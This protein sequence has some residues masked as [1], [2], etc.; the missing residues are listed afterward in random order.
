MKKKYFILFLLP[1]LCFITNHID[2]QFYSGQEDYTTTSAK[3]RK[4]EKEKTDENNSVPPRNAIELNLS[5]AFLYNINLTYERKIGRK[6]GVLLG[7]RYGP[8]L[9]LPF[10]S[11]WGG[12]IKSN[13]ITNFNAISLSNIAITP[14]IRY[15]FGKGFQRGFYIAGYARYV[16]YN[17]S[18]PLN[19][20]YNYQG[21]NISQNVN[22]NTN[23]SGIS[24]GLM[25]GLQ[26]PIGKHFQID[27][28]LIGVNYGKILT[29]QA[30]ASTPLLNTDAYN[31]LDDQIKSLQNGSASLPI[32]FNYSLSQTPS[33]TNLK[34]TVNGPI[35]GIRGLGINFGFRF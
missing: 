16:S 11:Q 25:F 2:A 14:E 26:Y 7:L 18:A 15:Y 9:P 4:L 22:I 3:H 17:L 28:W 8:Q 24:G 27:I 31:A 23:I 29:G 6:L 20:S 33:T 32:K 5:S 19:I 30:N 13:Y 12:A 1:L 34:A 10:V 21:I 35:I